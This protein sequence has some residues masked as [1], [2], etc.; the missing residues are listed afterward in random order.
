M[1]TYTM[2]DGTLSGSSDTAT[3]TTATLGMRLDALLSQLDHLSSTQLYALIVAATVAVCLIVLGTGSHED[4]VKQQEQQQEHQQTTSPEVIKPSTLLS[5]SSLPSNVRQ[6]RFWIFKYVN[7]M[8]SFLFLASILQFSMNAPY[9]ME[10]LNTFLMG[11][12]VLLCYFFGFFGVSLIHT[13]LLVEGRIATSSSTTTTAV[14]PRY[15]G[16]WVMIVQQRR[17]Q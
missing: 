8:V 1:S 7:A 5:S 12:S 15:E 3:T 16:L 4:D 17:C 14:V 6:P 11:W 2:M 9:Y 10:H 13:D